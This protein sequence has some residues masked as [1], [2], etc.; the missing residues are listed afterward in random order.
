MK[1]VSEFFHNNGLKIACREAGSG[2]PLLLL[3]GS[4]GTG[5]MWAAFS[6]G[7]SKTRRVIMPDLIGY[8]LSDPWPQPEIFALADEVAAL[9]V[10]LSRIDKAVDLVGYSYGGAVAL[11]L[12]RAFPEKIRSLV[13]IE[14]VLFDLLRQ[15]GDRAAY[16]EISTLR[17]AV[18]EDME[19]IAALPALRRFLAYWTGIDAK[20]KIPPTLAATPEKWVG[21][22][23][24]DW[25]VTFA[26]TFPIADLTKMRVPTTI[27]SGTI[28]PYSV[29]NLCQHLARFLPQCDHRIIDKAGHM[30]PFTHGPLFEKILRRHLDCTPGNPCLCAA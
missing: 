5:N 26:R 8:G 21:K 2:D 25:Q 18:A 10:L 30:L 14:P 15:V 22:I 20:E 16:T 7:L 23:L 27:V 3:H 28:S 19:N 11:E 9:D 24:L 29:K 17:D 13:L 4:L 1:V 12:T 6:Q